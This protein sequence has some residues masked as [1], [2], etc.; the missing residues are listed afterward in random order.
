[1]DLFVSL[2]DCEMLFAGG[3]EIQGGPTRGLY[4]R[5]SPAPQKAKQDKNQAVPTLRPWI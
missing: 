3:A 2:F 4:L 1:M 5:N